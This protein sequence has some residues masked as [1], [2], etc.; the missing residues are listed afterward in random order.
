MIPRMY[1]IHGTV[2]VVVLQK[3]F[4]EIEGVLVLWSV[5]RVEV[6]NL[7]CNTNGV[8][9]GFE[10]VYSS[11]YRYICSVVRTPTLLLVY[12]CMWLLN[13]YGVL[14]LLKWNKGCP[15]WHTWFTYIGYGIDCSG[16]V[17]NILLGVCGVDVVNYFKRSTVP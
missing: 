13:M 2:S 11:L 10:M 3:W 7:L 12:T 5:R 14:Y 16:Y 15:L 6:F 4:A 1:F 8:G 9:V 17:A